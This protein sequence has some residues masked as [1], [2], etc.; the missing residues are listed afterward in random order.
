MTDT[1]LAPTY[2][3]REHKRNLGISTA[4]IEARIDGHQHP[5]IQACEH[6][7]HWSVQAGPEVARA[8]ECGFSFPPAFNVRS[9]DDAYKWVSLLA[10]LYVKAVAA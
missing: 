6:D 5:F 2:R 7:T 10:G 4:V 3:I 1:I 9:A 8:I